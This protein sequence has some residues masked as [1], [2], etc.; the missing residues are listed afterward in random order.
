MLNGSKT[1]HKSHTHKS[2]IHTRVRRRRASADDILSL[3][4]RLF[5]AYT[6]GIPGIHGP[7]TNRAY[8]Q[9]LL[10]SAAWR[11]R[12]VATFGIC[13]VEQPVACW[14]VLVIAAPAHRARDTPGVLVRG[15]V[16][17]LPVVTLSVRVEYVFLC[18]WREYRCSCRQ[19]N[20]NSYA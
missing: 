14:S 8:K 3:A 9:T 15:P 18:V 16:A 7:V 19:R 10:S 20:A 17:L 4:T 12:T 11:I 13:S 1:T 2:N 5:T 6:L